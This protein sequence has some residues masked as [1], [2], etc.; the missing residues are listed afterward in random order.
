MNKLFSLLLS[1]ASLFLLFLENGLAQTALFEDGILT[2]P[3]AAVLNTDGVEYFSDVRLQADSNGSFK[4]VAAQPQNLVNIESVS[5]NVVESF[6]F[7]QVS[8]LVTGNKS[9]PCTKL[10]EPGI[11]ASNGTFTIALAESTLGPAET[12][13]AI[14]DPFET[15][16]SLDVTGLASGSYSVVVNGTAADFTL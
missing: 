15:T 10:L 13:I 6:P 7:A 1:I 16:I 9:L 11:F 5:V 12:C 8:V 2:I 14:I 4:L 3:Q